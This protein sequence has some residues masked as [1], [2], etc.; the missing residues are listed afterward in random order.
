MITEIANMKHMDTY[1]E[2]YWKH[3]LENWAF[4][5]NSGW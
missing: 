4:L 5:K 1:V 3:K 2:Q